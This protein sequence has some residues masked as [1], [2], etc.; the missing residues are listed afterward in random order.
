MMFFEVVDGKSQLIETP[1]PLL[2]EIVVTLEAVG[3]EKVSRHVIA[4]GEN[5]KDRRGR[6]QQRESHINVKAESELDQRTCAVSKVIPLQPELLQNAYVEIAERNFAGAFCGKLLEGAMLEAAS[7]EE[8]RQVMIGVGIGIAHS[9]SKENGSGDRASCLRRQR[10]FSVS[11]GIE[12]S[13]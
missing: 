10:C 8:D 11:Q 1:L 12:R 4:P 7:S 2:R 13:A 3:R 6:N 5:R 9:A